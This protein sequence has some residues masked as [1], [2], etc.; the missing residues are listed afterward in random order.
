[1]S[2]TRRESR[3]PFTTITFLKA[4]RVTM[5]VLF[6]FHSER[7]ERTVPAKIVWASFAR[8]EMS[9]GMTIEADVGVAKAPKARST[10]ITLARHICFLEG[11]AARV[12]T[13]VR[14]MM[15]QKQVI[16]QCPI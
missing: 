5:V 10:E 6:A 3:F 15:L 14:S 11:S 4:T 9:R 1:M 16:T 8:S 2:S 13:L 7:A 12:I